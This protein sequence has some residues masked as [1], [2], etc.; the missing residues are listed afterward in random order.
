MVRVWR[1]TSLLWCM[2]RTTSAGRR[3]QRGRI[4]TLPSD[5]LRVG[6]YAGTD[7]VMG[8]RHYLRE[9]IPAGPKAADEAE[10]VC[11]LSIR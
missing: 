10:R 9:V 6:V 1:E 3:R 8:K 7:R 5:A 4:E 11:G 2:T